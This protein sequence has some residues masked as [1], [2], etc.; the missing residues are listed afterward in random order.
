MVVLLAMQLSMATSIQ[1]NKHVASIHLAVK[2]EYQGKG[3][4]LALMEAVEKWSKQREISRLEL[5]VM[6][7]NDIA[8][9]LFNKLGFQ[10]EGIRKKRH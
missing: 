3:I 5:S 10:Q 6:E 1:K 7:H 2:E 9:N 8:L 4:G